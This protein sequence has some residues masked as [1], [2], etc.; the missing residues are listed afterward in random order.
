[1]AKSCT[2]ALLGALLVLSLLVS[3]IACS[4]KLA[5]AAGHHKPAPVKGHK[6]Q[7]TTNP[8][9]SAAYG[10]GWLPAGATYYGNPNGDGSDGGACGYQTAV[11]HRPFSSMIAAGSSPLFMA[12]KGCGACYDVKCTSNSACSGKPVT[13][14]ITDLS[15]GNLYPGEPCHFDMSGTALGAMA[16]PG[17]A[18]K[19][20][21]GGVIRMQY[22]RVPCKYPGVNI[23]FRVD[24]G[25]N[26]FYFKTLIEF[27]D[28]DGDLKAVALKEAGSGAWTPMAQ[29]WGAL[30]RLNN[31]RRLRAPF[32]LRLTSDSGRK[33]VVNNVIPAN[34]KAGATYRSL[35][36]YP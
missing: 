24:Q 17:M 14:V 23:A 32:S 5:K 10:G 12:G 20:R 15:P 22:K 16:K 13:V 36:N 30:W 19:L 26:P 3:P 4:R 8:S 11:G 28:D 27:E 1:M 18:D 33:L 6:N 34:W 35:V 21:A 29:D 9:S 7:T 31:G 2:L 25:A